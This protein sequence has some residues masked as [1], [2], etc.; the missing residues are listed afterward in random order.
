MLKFKTGDKVKVIAGKDKGREGEIEK[1]YP[2]E[3]KAIVPGANMYKKHV[4]GNQGQKGG[5]Y[6][7]PRPLPFAKLMVICPNCKKPS[8]L[9]FKLAGT[10][11]VRYCKNCKREIGKEVKKK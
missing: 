11:K 3:G 6:D 8:R 4:K 9:G 7:I 5:I 1:L 2:S 10:E